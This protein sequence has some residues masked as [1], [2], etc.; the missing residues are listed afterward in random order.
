MK[1]K[2]DVTEN[3]VEIRE[4]DIGD[5]FIDIKNF[6]GEKVL[7]VVRSE[8]YDCRVEFDDDISVIA[9]V[10]L[11]TG[12]LWS[13]TPDEEVVPVDTEEIKYKIS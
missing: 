7:M 5:T 2:S 13:Y 4:L 6:G 11:V 10:N 1:F 9:A 3:M 8:G 12:E